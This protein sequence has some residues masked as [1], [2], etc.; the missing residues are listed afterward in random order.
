MPVAIMF[1]GYSGIVQYGHRASLAMALG[2][3]LLLYAFLIANFY[4]TAP[5]TMGPGNILFVSLCGV[6]VSLM[7]VATRRDRR[8]D[9]VIKS[10]QY[11]ETF[12][13]MIRC[14]L[15]GDWFAV[16][17]H[18]LLQLKKHPKDI[19]ALLLQ[20]TMYRH[21]KRYKE[22]KLILD[23]LYLLQDSRFW[24]EEISAE[25]LLIVAAKND[26]T[27]KL[28]EITEITKDSEFIERFSQDNSIPIWQHSE[29]DESLDRNEMHDQ[30][31][32]ISLEMPLSAENDASLTGCGEEEGD[33]YS[34]DGCIPNAMRL[35]GTDQFSDEILSCEN[36]CAETVENVANIE[37]ENCELQ[38]IVPLR[39]CG[40]FPYRRG[41]K[42]AQR[43]SLLSFIKK[44][45]RAVYSTKIAENREI[46][47]N[48]EQH[49]ETQE[50]GLT[51]KLYREAEMLSESGLAPQEIAQQ[52]GI[53]LE[54]LDFLL[55][56]YQ[57]V[58]I[59][60]GT[61]LT[62]HSKMS[63]FDDFDGFVE[64]DETRSIISPKAITDNF[65]ATNAPA[66][67]MGIVGVG[68]C[69]NN[70]AQIF[71]R[72]GYRRVLLVN[73]AQTD[74]DSI[75]EQIPKLLIGKQGAGKD[76]EVGKA[77]VAEKATEIRNSILREFGEDFEKII[78]CIGLGGGTG[79]GGG[80]AVVKIAQDIVK[81]RG[82]DPAKDV[83]V[84]VTLPAPSMD[85][86]RQCFNALVA[87]GQIANLGV[88][89]IIID[90]AQIGSIIRAK[91]TEGWTPINTWIVRTF[92]TFNMYAT[93]PSDHGAF[94]G[95]DFNDV[96]G[97]GRLLF[98]AFRVTN[99]KDRYAI[100]DTMAANL[101]RSL[102]AKCDRA[103]ATAAGCLMVINP[104]IG[105]DLSMED[106]AP[107]FQ[108]LNS[109]MRPNSTL[110]RGIYIPDWSSDEQNKRPDL[111]CYIV[112]GGL[113]HPRVTLSGLFEKAKD[114]DQRYESV[115][116]FLDG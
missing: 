18:I 27:D 109:I 102:F 34:I 57:N 116:A 110:H 11:D 61:V 80:P 24:H 65:N 71:H 16:E 36:H 32:G 40:K 104:R 29:G 59:I 30:N 42:E 62:P 74:L 31:L 51:E 94:D 81:D 96:I 100:G 23:N 95:N 12:R 111:F 47:E 52:L 2:F 8:P 21:T 68:Q 55:Q 63:D 17:S 73:T 91:L 33:A 9:A 46:T 53:P 90:N 7:I 106:L 98:S 107:A 83:I 10:E 75:E 92:H 87:Y 60:T 67:K 76:P 115:E 79:S 50:T 64:A 20:A 66:F 39:L 56:I 97:R 22:A 1:P 25:Q 4:R 49:K 13:Q 88:P 78:V 35:L 37:D 99:L 15:R 86:P 3:A 105:K 14:Y 85:G 58:D 72:I 26:D 89:M 112:F 70:I 43:L 6:W 54:S 44:Q 5:I 69:G 84:I 108:E 101:Q 38:Q 19:E 48:P 28:K 45:F 77:C 93:M 41:H 114:F 82:G 103:T 113:D